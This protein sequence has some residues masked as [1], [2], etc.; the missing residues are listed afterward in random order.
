[1]SANSDDAARVG[2]L[3]LAVALVMLIAFWYSGFRFR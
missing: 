1:M 3:L 2:A